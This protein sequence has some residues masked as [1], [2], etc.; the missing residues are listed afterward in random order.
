[1]SGYTD[2]Q[3][4]GVVLSEFE[5]ATIICVHGHHITISNDEISEDSV[6]PGTVPRHTTPCVCEPEKLKKISVPKELLRKHTNEA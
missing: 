2:E 5:H 1:M 4:S 6:L 3:V